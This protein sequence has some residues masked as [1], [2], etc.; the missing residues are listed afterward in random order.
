M[1]VPSFARSHPDA[2]TAVGL[3][4]GAL[5]LLCVGLGSLSGIRHPDEAYYLSIILEMDRTG[6]WVIPRID[7]MASFFKPPL[8]YWAAL[9]SRAVLGDNLFATRLPGA[10]FA[11]GSVSLTYL[12][13]REWCERRTAVLAAVLL[14]SMLGVQRFGR[15]AM[16]ES[17]LMF[18]AALAVYGAALSKRWRGGL[19]LTGMGAALSVLTKWHG[20]ALVPLAAA[21]C[22]L[23]ATRNLRALFSWGALAGAAVAVLLPLPWFL[24]AAR[25]PAFAGGFVAENI[26]RLTEAREPPISLLGVPLY[27]L[28]FSPLALAFLASLRPSMLREP[29]VLVPLGW[30]AVVLAFWLLPASAQYTHH[31]QAGLP[32]A[33]L[34]AAYAL[35]ERPFL[36]RWTEKGVAVALLIAGPLLS[37]AALLV[38]DAWSVVAILLA[39]VAL[40]CAG[41]LLFSARALAGVAAAALAMALTLGLALPSADAEFL[42]RDA[43]AKLKDAPLDS[44]GSYPGYF[45]FALGRPIGRLWELPEVEQSLR[46]G[47]TVILDTAAVELPANTPITEVARWERTSPRIGLAA[48][49][50]ALRSRSLKPVRVGQRAVRMAK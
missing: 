33:A 28:P 9:C 43:A 39:A 35:S 22:A 15:S 31:A 12:L 41:L 10:L 30:L 16:L 37:V 49:R 38:A 36:A 48:L 20:V 7:G 45:Q 32:A 3:F 40:F 46:A 47:R 27:G 23:V 21:L 44:Y 18:G 19:V 6:E 17:P 14:A 1:T 50:E 13:A 26:A 11:A 29:R 5:A 42:P 24:L 2:V 4:A 25:D 34:L 8:L